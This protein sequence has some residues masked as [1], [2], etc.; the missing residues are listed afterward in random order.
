MQQI[1]RKVASI[2][3]LRRQGTFADQALL[4]AGSI[5]R[6]ASHVSPADQ[7]VLAVAFRTDT[8]GS[9][10]VLATSRCSMMLMQAV[11]S[12]SGVCILQL[13]TEPPVHMLSLF[14]KHCI[15]AHNLFDMHV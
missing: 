1:A 12:L 5:V 13:A 8:V 3:Q 4:V 10:L 11:R 15:Y 2:D 6:A 14:F 9:I 7:C